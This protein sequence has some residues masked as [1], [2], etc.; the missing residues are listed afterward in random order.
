M[1]PDISAGDG[2]YDGNSN[3]NVARIGD[4]HRNSNRLSDGGRF[5]KQRRIQIHV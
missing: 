1:S 4:R 2:E 5:F 3:G